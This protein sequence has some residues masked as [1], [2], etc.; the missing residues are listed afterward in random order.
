MLGYNFKTI[1]RERKIELGSYNLQDC[2]SESE[3]GS[4][5]LNR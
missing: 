1:M 3:K 5:P 2:R 4:A